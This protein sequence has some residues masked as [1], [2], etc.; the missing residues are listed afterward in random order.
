MRVAVVLV[1]S[2]SALAAA[3]EDA[4]QDGA[5][6]LQAWAVDPLVKVFRDDA[7]G[8]LRESTADAARGE[9]ATFQIV[10]R[11]AEAISKL[12]CQ[13][14]PL[15]HEP[16]RRRLARAV[17]R[18]VGYVPVDLGTP[19]PA[20]DQLRKPPGDFPDPL[21]ESTEI[22]VMPGQAQPV[23]I[24]LN[25]PLDA[26]PGIYRGEAKL[27]GTVGRSSKSISIPLALTV[28]D[29]R[30]DK[31][32]LLVS[33]WFQMSHFPGIAFPRKDSPEYWDLLRRYALDMAAHRQN[34]ARVSPL[35]L[36]NY[37]YNG[38]RMRV[39]FTR[40]DRWV[41]TFLAA[42]V[43]ARVE[44]QQLGWRK[45]DWNGPFVVSTYVMKDAK[46]VEERVDPASPQ[47][48]AFYAQFLPALEK[49]LRQRGW[50]AKYV[51]HVADEPN[52]AN[53]DSYR[54][55]S[56]LVRKHAP[57]FKIIDAA[58][59]TQLDGAIDIWV[60]HLDVFHRNYAHYQ[61]RKNKG[62]EVWYYTCVAAQ[63]EYANR[64]VELPLL[65]TRLLHWINYR[66]GASGYLH[67]GYN[68]WTKDPFTDPVDNR[69]NILLPAGEAWIVY[70]GKQGVMGSIR[71][72]AMRDG[73]A[74]YE[75]FCQLAD[76]G[77]AA[78]AM[79]LVSKHVL[80]FD[81]YDCDVKAFRATRRA[82]LELLASSATGPTTK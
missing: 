43:D 35:R 23:W 37:T 41:R 20:K 28:Y 78:E 1:A 82:L 11:S 24:S 71:F 73:I 3:A 15:T 38:Q 61:E 64:Y 25:I 72:D 45:G 36:A 46:V 53:A 68:Y 62:E 50:L 40:F 14:K 59:T 5:A 48:D 80:D 56:T 7:P 2:A 63:G 79:A 22:D 44:G 12:R 16:T 17:V 13:V 30:I 69:P 19:S 51:Q 32:R 10:V 67:W 65:K 6:G 26:K 74:D 66:Y 76:R 9:H 31:S 49:H 47:A 58:F 75:L 77:K 60:P 4:R 39:D 18:F 55:I 54:A 70:P 33:N 29:A 52:D 81:R 21:L 57:G 34:V 27:L 42:G 8:E